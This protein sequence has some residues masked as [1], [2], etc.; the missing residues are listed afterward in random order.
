[1]KPR[2]SN[3]VVALLVLIV[4]AGCVTVSAPDASTGPSAP[5]GPSATT[6]PPPA[7]E[8]PWEAELD[9]VA[10]DGSRSLDSALQ[11]FAM[12]YGPVPGVEDAG[13][14]S[15]AVEGTLARRAVLG[16]YDELTAEQKIAVD[17][18]LAPDPDAPFVLIGPEAERSS[19]RNALALSGPGLF[20]AADEEENLTPAQQAVQDATTDYR[21]A[22]EAKIGPIPGPIKLSFP[23][24][25]DPT[26][27]ADADGI[28]VNNVYTGCE[29]RWFKN[30]L[31]DAALNILLTAAHEVFHCFQ[32][33]AIQPRL[34]YLLAPD[35]YQEG[36][37]E[38][39]SYV[40][41]GAPQDT[42][43]WTRY[44]DNPHKPL[45]AR[46]YDAV[47]F[48]ADLD[49]TGIDPWP[50]WKAIWAAYDNEPAWVA[51]GGEADRFLDSWA[52]GWFRDPARGPDWEMTGPGI[53]PGR[54]VLESVS[55]SN[56]S[57]AAVQADPYTN[58][59]Y[60]A[61]SGADVF[62]VTGTGHIRIS[63]RTIDEP[64]PIG[65]HFCTKSGGCTCPDGKPPPFP[66]TDLAP[67]FVVAVTGGSTGANANLTGISLED[68]CKE[69]EESKAV[70]VKKDRPGSEGVL[71]GEVVDL[72]SCDGPYG[73][74]TGVFRT[75]GLSNQ[76]FEVPWT[77]VPVQFTFPAEGG[78]QTAVTT[79][80]AIVPTPIGDFPVDYVVT[81][82]V[83]GGLMTVDLEPG[84]EGMD[85]QLVDMPIQ[86]AP[87]GACPE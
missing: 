64:Q 27:L 54:N 83:N 22:I 68:A 86:P 58:A 23:D 10:P 5:S 12:A 37:A 74:W 59:Q 38:W 87:E 50:R 3:L 2:R 42:G 24:I 9:D 78:T 57:S 72:L 67:F 76:G 6:A 29:I 84:A 14:G 46:T 56:G 80:S 16:H 53:P 47:G 13:R 33:A 60:N 11:L 4:T 77:D 52:S 7:A 55:V 1:V 15:G 73:S 61:N 45:F 65:Q 70:M 28:W 63:D 49:A 69:E 43:F 48:W 8:T 25:V 85:N 44:V 30:G 41:A 31:A 79:A 62:V 20:I 19:P 82:T 71:P 40:I 81:V 39:V 26:A 75:G 17:A 66:V 34:K 36:G 51:T 35:W 21:F 18:W 32:A